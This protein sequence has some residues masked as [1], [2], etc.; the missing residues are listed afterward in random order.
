MSDMDLFF[1]LQN[2]M[3]YGVFNFETM[4]QHPYGG[5]CFLCVLFFRER[6]SCGGGTWRTEESCAAAWHLYFSPVQRKQLNCHKIGCARL[7]HVK[8]GGCLFYL[9]LFYRHSIFRVALKIVLA[10][11]QSL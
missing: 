6:E 5:V 9:L 10:P 2:N 1:N 3:F 4:N 11:S 8:H 7:S